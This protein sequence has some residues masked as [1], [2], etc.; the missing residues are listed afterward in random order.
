MFPQK[1]APLLFGFILSGTLQCPCWRRQAFR[2]SAPQALVHGFLACLDQR[3]AHEGLR[4]SGDFRS[5]C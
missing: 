2:W 1:F 3:L 4:C 5:C